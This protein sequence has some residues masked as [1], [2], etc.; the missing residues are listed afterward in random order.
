[1]LIIYIILT[2]FHTSKIGCLFCGFVCFFKIF[3][4]LFVRERHREHER[5]EAQSERVSRLPTEQG[6]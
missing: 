6:V 4:N 1:M 2:A 3:S 5:G